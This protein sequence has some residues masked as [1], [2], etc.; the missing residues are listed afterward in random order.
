MC[1]CVC[2]IHYPPLSS[3]L[4]KNKWKKKKDS[5]YIYF[6]LFQTFSVKTVKMNTCCYLSII[7]KTSYLSAGK[8]F[9]CTGL[10][11][12]L[13]DALEEEMATHSS[14]LAWEIPWT[15]EPGKLHSMESQRFRHNQAGTHLSTTIISK[16]P[17]T[18]S[19]ILSLPFLQFSS[20]NCIVCFFY[21]CE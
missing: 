13:Q 20:W 3:S 6:G 1:V 16:Y 18:G 21:S 9:T 5:L 19:I 2:V 12:G 17:E 14:I 8:E 4:D 11:L 7:F 10:I 15:E